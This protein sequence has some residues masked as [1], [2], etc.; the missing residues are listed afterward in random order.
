MLPSTSPLPDIIIFI[1][2]LFILFIFIFITLKLYYNYVLLYSQ[3][4][5]VLSLI[6]Y[7]N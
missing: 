5:Q 7:E 1:T 6:L 4:Q 2:L 3:F